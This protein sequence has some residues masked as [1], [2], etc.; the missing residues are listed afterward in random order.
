MNYQPYEGP[1]VDEVL[2]LRV[3]FHAWVMG[4]WALPDPYF[5]GETQH[6]LRYTAGRRPYANRVTAHRFGK[7]WADPKY[8]RAGC[9]VLKCEGGESCPSQ[10]DRFTGEHVP[11]GGPQ[12]DNS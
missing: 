9:T 2:R 7:Q 12:D 11:P 4:A 6:A 5:P 10:F 8:G 1:A 3:H